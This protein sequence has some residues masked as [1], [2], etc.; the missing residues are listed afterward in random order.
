MSTSENSTSIAAEPTVQEQVNTETTAAEAPKV[1]EEQDTTVE[2]PKA[3][4]EQDTTVEAPK[5]NE[6]QAATVEAPKTTE[7][8]D[9]TVEAPKT[10]EEQA[11]TATTTTITPPLPPPPPFEATEEAIKSVG[12]PT[13]SKSNATSKRLSAFLGKAKN[14]VDKKVVAE[15]KST[16][17]ESEVV[18]EP[19]A[20]PLEEFKNEKRKSILG[21]IFRSKSPVPAASSKETEKS[22]ELTSSKEESKSEELTDKGK[23]Q[24]TVAANTSATE[25]PNEASTH[26]DH[27]M[28]DTFKKGP[29]GKL[30]NKKKETEHH[31]EDT[32]PTTEHVEPSTA[33]S[34]EEQSTTIEPTTAVTNHTESE[35]VK[36]PG[37]PIGRRITQMF[38]GFSHKKKKEDETVAAAAAAEETVASQ[39]EEEPATAAAVTTTPVV[40]A[41]A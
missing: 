15:R 22:E 7:E 6:E 1:N 12:E 9:T 16:V 14:F 20:E 37:S 32:A 34:K 18:V 27:N 21:N 11:T 10:N 25:E 31:K 23:I 36:R 19:S 17:K 26:K 38:R 24:E 4:E 29:L 2:A 33:V 28:M 5:A 30:F 8:Q 39:H 13:P 41:T 3:N 35:E 40:Q